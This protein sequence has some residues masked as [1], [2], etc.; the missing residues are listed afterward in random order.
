M[1]VYANDK[2]SLKKAVDS[3]A[4][5][6]IVT[7]EYVK[8]LKGLKAM[9]KA[10]PKAVAAALVAIAAAVPTAIVI[11]ATAPETAGFSIVAGTPVIVAEATV[12]SAELCVGIGVA[13]SLI[14]LAATIS[15]A[16]FKALNND[17]DVEI[18][19]DG[20]GGMKAK[21]TRNKK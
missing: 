5:V 17:Y 21:F 3:K 4:D 12:V 2:D 9:K 16:T 6:I 7:G 20:K 8:K 13:V 10:R 15:I 1:T 14:I 19:A 18:G 11:L